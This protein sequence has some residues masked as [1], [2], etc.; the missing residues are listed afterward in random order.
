MT[1]S[2]A[3]PGVLRRFIKYMALLTFVMFSV[4]AVVKMAQNSVPGDM[5]VRQGDIFL[6]DDKF[7]AAITKFDDALKIQ[8]DHRGA[9]AGKGVALMALN[10]YDEAERVFSYS[11][12]YLSENLE[13]DDPTGKGALSASYANRGIIK[14]RTGRYQ[15]ALEDYIEA[16]KL[17]YDLAEGP[18]WIQHILYYDKKP[19]SVLGRAKYLY[20]QLQLPQ[21]Q[22]LM[23][24]P[25]LDAKQR[26]Y[27]PR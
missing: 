6:Q 16:I 12:R 27:K 18:G 7:A 21:D 9:L 19:S 5:E 10:Q 8:P 1:T 24:V 4:W 25:D 15:E 13:A 2:L 22:R 17:D 14:D 23:R 11:I 3:T 20:T 26:R